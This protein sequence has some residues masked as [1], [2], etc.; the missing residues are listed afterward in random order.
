MKKSASLYIVILASW[1]ALIGV[2]AVP[3][4]EAV[5]NSQTHGVLIA[6]LV[7]MSTAFIMYFWLNG[8]KDLIYTIYYFLMRN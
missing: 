2:S 6:S 7:A 3:F 5:K 4:M 1:A 8:T